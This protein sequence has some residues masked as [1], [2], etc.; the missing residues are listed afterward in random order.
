M[1]LKTITKNKMLIGSILF[2]GIVWIISISLN[3]LAVDQVSLFWYGNIFKPAFTPSGWIFQ[4]IWLVLY[5]LAGI[6]LYFVLNSENIN[7]E[8]FLDKLKK[9]GINPEFYSNSGNK[10]LALIIFGIY[11]LLSVLQIPVFIGLRST[12]GGFMVSILLWVSTV[13][14]FYKFYKITIPAAFLTIPAI[15]CSGYFMG[16]SLTFWMLNN[17]SW[18]LGSFKH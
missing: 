2:S 11:L 4:G 14:T 12:L 5:L 16:L 18:L 10:K 15:L 6:S 1:N 3:K 17:T 7:Q 8:T 13:F 9:I